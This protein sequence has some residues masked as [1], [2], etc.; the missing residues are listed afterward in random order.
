VQ[1]RVAAA[2]RAAHRRND[3]R[4][5]R[6]ACLARI[7]KKIRKNADDAREASSPSVQD[8]LRRKRRSLMAQ[9]SDC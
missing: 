6:E 9:R 4:Q 8:K 3:A 2:S 5:E 7:D 1:Q